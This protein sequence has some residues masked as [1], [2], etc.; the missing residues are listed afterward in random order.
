VLEPELRTGVL[1][2]AVAYPRRRIKLTHNEITEQIEQLADREDPIGYPLRMIGMRDSR[3]E[4]SWMHN[5]PLLMRGDRTPR[6]LMHV[7]DAARRGIADGD[8]VAVRS[9][10]G[11]ISLPARLTEDI[12]AGTVAI[13]HGWGHRGG[14]WRVA[15]AVGGV[16]VNELTS[17]DPDDVEALSGMAWLTGVP[18]EVER[19]Q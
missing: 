8:E 17:N 18:I 3:S 9:P 12:V 6:A 5:A 7:D 19:S 2:S 1:A 10:Y 14:G 11:K 15:N 4:N 16:N 13:P